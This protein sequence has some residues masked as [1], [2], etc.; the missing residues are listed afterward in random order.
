KNPYLWASVQ[1]IVNLSMPITLY[2]L[3]ACMPKYPAFSFGLAAFFLVVG[4]LP[5]FLHISLPAGC[6][7]LLFCVNSAIIL[8]A[9]RR[10][11]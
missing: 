1:L 9:E 7:L 8:Y 5:T 6:I 4:L 2:L 11:K 10:V 3:Y